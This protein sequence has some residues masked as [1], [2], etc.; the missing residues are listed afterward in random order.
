[1]DDHTCLKLHDQAD[2]L[3]NKILGYKEPKIGNW[4]SGAVVFTPI[5]LALVSKAVNVP[6][7]VAIPCTIVT[8]FIAYISVKRRWDIWHSMRED[9]HAILKNDYETCRRK[10]DR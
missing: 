10:S 5:A 8:A 2:R 3:T 7:W 1:M 9:H 6:L 4:V